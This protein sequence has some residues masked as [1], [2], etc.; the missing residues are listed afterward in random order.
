MALLQI[1]EV[2]GHSSTDLGGEAQSH[3]RGKYCP[4]RNS[5]CTK[6]SSTDPIG[7]CSLTDGQRLATL[8]PVRFQEQG[9]LFRD[10]GRIAFGPGV[11]VVAA[12][13][14]HVLRVQDASKNEKKS[15]R[16]GKVD[17]LIARINEQ[18]KAVDFAAMEV[19][20]VYFS[21]GEIKTAFKRYLRTGKLDESSARRPDWRSSIQ[22][23]LMPQLSLK[24]PVFRRW[25]KKFFVATDSLFFAQ[26]PKIRTINSFA[27]SEVTWMVYPFEEYDGHFQMGEPKVVY[28]LWDDVLT[29]LREGVAPD[30]AEI[31]DEIE[32]KR[33]EK[34]LPVL[35]A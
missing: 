12:P 18:N 4:F 6:S 13:E 1:G 31:L 25:G 2:F 33:E 35:T 16:I 5:A 34:S 32:R 23:R 17:F 27:N 15:K 21:G 7:I 9:R 19:Q 28:T 14:V 11:K 8:C 29:A 10:V 20:A 26:V 22:K 30:P 24:I 3:R